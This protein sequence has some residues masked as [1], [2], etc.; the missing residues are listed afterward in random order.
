M[1]EIEES[2]TING[3]WNCKHGGNLKVFR[4]LLRSLNLEYGVKIPSKTFDKL[5]ELVNSRIKGSVNCNTDVRY[6]CE[7]GFICNRWEYN[8]CGFQEKKE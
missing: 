2:K 8:N 3:C 5:M 6:H 4:T 7:T 1:P